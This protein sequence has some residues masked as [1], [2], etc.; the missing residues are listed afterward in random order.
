M[1]ELFLTSD[2][3]VELTGRRRS[4]AQKSALSMMGV[5]FLIRPDGT[6]VVSRRNVEELLGV[7]PE[8]VKKKPPNEPNW[9]AM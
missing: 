2:E 8:K 3:L 7:R 9:D 1:S 4:G 6:L 5:N